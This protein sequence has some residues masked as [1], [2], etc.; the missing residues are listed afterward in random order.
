M[1]AVLFVMLIVAINPRVVF[2]KLL[3]L[4]QTLGRLGDV[5]IM[6]ICH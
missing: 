3:D 5:Y 4:K 6:A 1:W 2:H